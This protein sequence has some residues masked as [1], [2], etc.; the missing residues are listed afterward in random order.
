MHP[1]KQHETVDIYFSDVFG[2]APRDIEEYGAVDVS[3]VNDLPLFIDPFLLFNSDDPDYR[4]LHGGIIA[5]L[6]FLRDK[7]ASGTINPGLLKAWYHFKEVKENWLGFSRVGN[8]GTALGGRFARSLHENLHSIFK[9]FGNEKIARGSHL[10]KVCLVSPGVGRDNISDFTTCLIKWYLLEYTQAFARRFLHHRQ[11]RAFAVR[12]TRFNYATESWLTETYELPHHAGEFVILT[13]KDILTRDDTWISRSD[14]VDRFERITGALPN[15]ELRA[16]LNNFL[17]SQLG[18]DPKASKKDREQERRRAIERALREF[19]EVIEYYIRQKEDDGEAA[20]EASGAKVAETEELFIAQ[21][22]RFVD[23]YLVGS[24]FY[25]NPGETFAEVRERVLFLKRVIEDDSGHRFFVRD[26]KP[27]TRESDL[28][29]FHLLGWYARPAVGEQSDRNGGRRG[30]PPVEFKLASNPHLKQTVATFA[31]KEPG[32]RADNPMLLVICASSPEE[33]AS[34]L[35]MVRDAGLVER[36]D[37]V[38]ISLY[39]RTEGDIVADDAEDRPSVGSK[40]SHGDASPR[41]R[42]GNQAGNGLLFTDLHDRIAAGQVVVVAGAG[43]SIR[44]SG[45]QSVA[46]W[47]GLLAD[48]I[49]R[50]VELGQ[51]DE[52]WA[53][54]RREDLT[55]G[56]MDELLSVAEQVTQRLGGPGGGEFRRWLRETVGTLKAQQPDVL[57]ALRDLGVPLASTNYDGLIE[58]VTHRPPVTWKESADVERVL[59]GDEDAVLH[60]HGYWRQA[61]SVVLGVRSYDEV[62]GDEHAQ[63]VL[64]GLRLTRSLLFVGFG[65]GLTDPNFS[66]FLRWTRTAFA[67][68]EYRHFRLV[69]NSDVEHISKTHAAEER[70]FVLPYGESH[71][72]LAGFLRQ[73]G[74]TA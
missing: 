30:K 54:R 57:E 41:P 21:V 8:R 53:R 52:E 68:S 25:A 34:V 14:L 55:S 32:R 36:P 51:G 66:T 23:A 37:V 63:A 10:E 73:L 45:G 29:L 74:P 28:Q 35:A 70:I 40:G 43:V 4:E 44:S 49:G 19:P 9:D 11:R 17:A 62:M 31:A 56:Q 59:R 33:R 39:G 58:E 67:S 38:I 3:L 72:D 7:S 1:N 24:D 6:Q 65:A 50:C 5:Y 20:A 22:R 26:G 71:D 16:Q 2:V 60:L 69:R 27:I 61:G 48:G 12:K 18:L 64:R 13:P 46:S 15:D 47:T 42:V